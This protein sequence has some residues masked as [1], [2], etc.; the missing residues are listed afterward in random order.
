MKQV[1][2]ITDIY[3]TFPLKCV[4]CSATHDGDIVKAIEDGWHASVYETGSGG[5]VQFAGC[6]DHRIEYE[7][8]SL[9][10]LK[11]KEGTGD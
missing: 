6:P 2:E 3:P 9:A 4:A 5:L 1:E 10:F 8:E 11:G 7:R